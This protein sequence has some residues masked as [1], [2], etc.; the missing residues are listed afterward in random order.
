LDKISAFLKAPFRLGVARH[1]T[2]LEKT[3]RNGDGAIGGYDPVD[4][5]RALS[6][7]GAP[8]FA[9]VLRSGPGCMEVERTLSLPAIPL[10]KD[11]GDRPE[12]QKLP[13]VISS[14]SVNANVQVNPLGMDHCYRCGPELAK[15]KMV[16]AVRY[17]IGRV[18]GDTSAGNQLSGEL[19][20]FSSLLNWKRQLEKLKAEVDQAFSRVCE[21][22][23]EFGPGLKP[24][25]NGRKRK[26]KLKKKRRLR[27]VRK[28]PKPNALV[29]LFVTR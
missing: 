6:K 9:D 20:T 4:T 23:L 17:K 27:W 18:H 7:D 3:R 28:D 2:V 1:A 21:G 29:L 5:N 15:A 11:R 12:E 16:P 26:N 19:N 10:A 22:I 13:I 25:V 14:G 8:S 24:K